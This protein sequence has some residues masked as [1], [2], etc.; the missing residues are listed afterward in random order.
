MTRYLAAAAAFL[1]AAPAFAQ[2]PNE[3]TGKVHFIDRQEGT[4]RLDTSESF[5][6]G[7]QV[8][9]AALKVGFAVTVAFEGTPGEGELVATEIRPAE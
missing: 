4:F 1:F 2:S 6:I 5:R 8:D 9:T 7:E 3:A